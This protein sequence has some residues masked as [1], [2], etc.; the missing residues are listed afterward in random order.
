MTDQPAIPARFLP[1][2]RQVER[3][4]RHERYLGAFV[5]GSVARGDAWPAGMPIR[6]DLD[7]L[8]LTR[9]RVPA[10]VEDALVDE[11]YPLFLESGRQIG[12]TFWSRERL[13][14]PPDERARRFLENVR[15]EAVPLRRRS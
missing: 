12:P 11:T 10:E 3:L 7:L 9:G 14:H 6:S 2:Y 4:R 5:F 1:A 8:V 15:R 13:E